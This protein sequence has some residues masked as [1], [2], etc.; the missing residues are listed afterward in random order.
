M[1]VR[2]LYTHIGPDLDAHTGRCAV[3]RFVPGMANAKVIYVP[4][5]W[6]GDG[7][8]KGDMAIDLVAGGK[9]IKGHRDPDGST[10][11]AFAYVVNK[12]ASKK[13][14]EALKDLVSFVD[15]QDA[16]GSVMNYLIRHTGHDNRRI[17]SQNSFGAVFRALDYAHPN[18]SET[19]FK[20]MLEIFDGYLLMGKTRALE[21]N[22]SNLRYYFACWFLVR[23]VKVKDR[24]TAADLAGQAERL[25]SRYVTDNVV[26]NALRD[27]V[28]FID[29]YDGNM[30]DPTDG[31]YEAKRILYNTSIT[32][33]TKALEHY[34][35]DDEELVLQRMSEI[36]DGILEAAGP[37]EVRAQAE[38]DRAKLY[39]DGRVA[40]V[41]NKKEKRTNQILKERGVL[42]IVYMA[43]NNLGV[44]ANNDIYLEDGSRFRADHPKICR[45]IEE[46]GERV[47]EEKIDDHDW[48]RHPRGFLCGHGSDKA[49]AS[50]RSKV[51]PSKLVE[52]VSSLIVTSR[53]RRYRSY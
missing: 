5:S 29:E 34:H 48:F 45:L 3:T 18:D 6:D 19:V 51:D 11:S 36:F 41:V 42:A 9:G 30:P 32:S 26:R 46:S 35:G 15:I 33:V 20:R 8:R 14:K 53:K 38:A 16:Y 22:Y 37:A 27:L 12:Y 52:V 43:G 31:D 4:A 24:Y 1:P 17:C 7:L 44:L 21:K 40:F 50:S 10:H 2:Y 39:A 49:P 28:T 25:V 13:E 47:A 23:F